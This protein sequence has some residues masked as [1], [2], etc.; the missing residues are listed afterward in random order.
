[1]PRQYNKKEWV[2]RCG[3]DTKG[4][5]TE[6]IPP[7]KGNSEIYVYGTKDKMKAMRFTKEEAER[8]AKLR[9]ADMIQV[10]YK[11]KA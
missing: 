7:K 10:N 5:L 9:Q 11:A 6:I 3:G 8:I 2:I 1:M 4:Y